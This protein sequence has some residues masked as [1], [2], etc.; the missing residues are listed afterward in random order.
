MKI[1]DLLLVPDRF[2]REREGVSGLTI[3]V[4]II[5]IVGILSAIGAYFVT[6]V[7]LQVVVPMLP[8]DGQQIL[9]IIM[10]LAVVWGAIFPY[11]QWLVVTIIFFGL[12]VLFKGTGEISKSFEYIGY[13]FLPQ[14]F[15]GV[16]NIYLSY[17]FA[18]TADVPR[19]TDPTLINQV[20]QSLMNNPYFEL[21]TLVGVI[22]LL[23]STNIWIFGLRYAR[24]MDI[25]DAAISVGVPVGIYIL[26][27]L[28]ST[29]VLGGLFA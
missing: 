6:P 25:R 3:P 21:A 10:A 18:V 29:G 23:W 5:G 19:V 22:F 16:I 4:L 11:I 2:F 7:T 14:I 28:Y 26:Y 8:S 9:G 13:G 1:P 24:N 12:S 15:G 17:L 20:T 27:T